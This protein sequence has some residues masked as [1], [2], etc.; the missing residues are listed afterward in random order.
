MQAGCSESPG[1]GLGTDESKQRKKVPFHL[2]PK[3]GLKTCTLPTGILVAGPVVAVG[4]LPSW[5]WGQLVRDAATQV[6][7]NLGPLN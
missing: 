3:T 7:E 1:Q 2:L 6:E 4:P 5:R